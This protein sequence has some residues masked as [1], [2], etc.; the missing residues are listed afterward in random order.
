MSHG[1][2]ALSRQVDDIAENCLAV[3]TR[4]LNRV[5]THVYDEALRPLG[6]KVSQMNILVVAHKL[7]RARPAEVC[8]ILKLDTSTLS[9][10]VDRMRAKGWL[11]TLDDQDGRAHPFKLTAEGKNLIRKAYPA[12][13]EAQN[14][15]AAVLGEAGVAL[16]QG[17]SK[18][19]GFSE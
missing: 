6:L 17:I 8:K 19:M 3:R 15:S 13:K 11:E 16:L 10:N 9:R 7:G 5:I 12:W 1:N 2:Q 18:E 4:L 14:K